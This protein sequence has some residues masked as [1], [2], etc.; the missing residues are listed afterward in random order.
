LLVSLAY[1]L[2]RTTA[3]QVSNDVRQL[4]GLLLKNFAISKREA[5][6]TSTPE[7]QSYVKHHALLAAQD[8][9]EQVRNIA[10][11]LITTLAT[12]L[13][14]LGSAHENHHH[15]G[16]D[17]QRPQ[18]NSGG[19]LSVYWPELLPAVMEMLG[20]QQI[21][22]VEGA[23]SCLL[24]IFEDAGRELQRDAAGQHYLNQFVSIFLTF[25][26][27][28]VRLS[29]LRLVVD[30]ILLVHRHEGVC[31]PSFAYFDIVLF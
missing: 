23:F 16:T 26:S 19:G 28:Q 30:I 11:I 21:H 14:R 25:F 9:N 8:D 29:T 7:L 31:P 18:A 17:Q 20:S 13:I 1:I 5:F 27:C 10:G 3:A 4:A 24:K 12:R 15:G 22:R 2:A 6:L